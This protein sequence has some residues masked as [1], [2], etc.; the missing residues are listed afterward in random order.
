MR[1]EK[2]ING[3]TTKLQAAADEWTRLASAYGALDNGIKPKM[4]QLLTVKTD[5]TPDIEQTDKSV[6][7]ALELLSDAI[8]NL[9]SAS[10]GYADILKAAQEGIERHLELLGTADVL[11]TLAAVIGG[12]PVQKAAQDTAEAEADVTHTRI[13]DILDGLAD[14]RNLTISVLDGASTTLTSAVGTKFN[15]VLQKQLQRPPEPTKSE[16]ARENKAR[17]AR[18]ET[19]A[20]IDPTKKK[21]SIPSQTGASR[22]IPDDLDIA[23]RTLTEVKNVGYQAYT[24]QIKDFRLYTQARG[25]TFDLIVDNN[26]KLAPEIEDLVRKKEINLVRMDLNS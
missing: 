15:P 19:R 7:E 13:K 17:G 22:R 20:G 26:T 6:L 5:E 11:N 25:Y 1:D 16:R 9:A 2:W 10:S 18:A 3:D 8:R 24:D 23:N 21:I 14:S 12:K 4:K